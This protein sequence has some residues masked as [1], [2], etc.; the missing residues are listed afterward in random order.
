MHALKS[1]ERF[2]SRFQFI[3]IACL[4]AIIICS[5]CVQCIRC[6]S[7]A[8]VGNPSRPFCVLSAM[9]ALNVNSLIRVWFCLHCS[10][11]MSASEHKVFWDA[12]LLKLFRPPVVFSS[13][14]LCC[15]ECPESETWE[16]QLH[17][18][19]RPQS[20][21]SYSCL[22]SWTQS[23][24]LLL[25]A[26]ALVCV[27]CPSFVCISSCLLFVCFFPSCFLC[28]ASFSLVVL[29]NCAFVSVAPCSCLISVHL[30]SMLLFILCLL[31]LSS[32]CTFLSC[33]SWIT[34]LR[35]RLRRSSEFLPLMSRTRSFG[36]ITPTP[37]ETGREIGW[38]VSFS[39][40][41]FV[42]FRFASLDC[43][44]LR[45]FCSIRRFACKLGVARFSGICHLGFHNLEGRN[46][47][48]FLS[49][50]RFPF[51]IRS[52][53]FLSPHF[54]LFSCLDSRVLLLL[55][56]FSS[57]Q[58]SWSLAGHCHQRW[59]NQERCTDD[60]LF[61]SLLSDR[62]MLA[63]CSLLSC[64]RSCFFCVSAFVSPLLV[65]DWFVCC[66]WFFCGAP[67]WNWLRC[68]SF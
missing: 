12:S 1:F 62:L 40:R 6:L 36:E 22:F 33:S 14:F 53:L 56:F 2:C 42:G 68:L 52:S 47:S 65:A 20:V 16:F 58:V 3:D 26:S 24:F 64:S 63:L 29:L 38:I 31:F 23:L 9:S 27:F 4:S 43:V 11:L 32:S 44:L 10:R 45:T 48:V 41:K 66:S 5:R 8:L 34:A 7:L 61:R 55:S 67:Y 13:F 19:S 17:D 49:F 57:S 25:F 35:V 30:A 54:H 28:S 37:C 39:A 18:S 60:S 46:L 21:N 50:H 15:T 59:T 51:S